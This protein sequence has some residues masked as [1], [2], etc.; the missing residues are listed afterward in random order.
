MARRFMSYT[1]PRLY[2]KD[3]KTLVATPG[4]DMGGGGQ[5]EVLHRNGPW[6]VVRMKGAMA[7]GGNGMPWRY[8]PTRYCAVNVETWEQDGE[9]VEPGRF[10]QKT[11]KELKAQVDA[12][13]GGTP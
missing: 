6:A 1:T 12:L 2:E 3:G 10:W 8:S 4:V 13:A 11:V 7:W 9:A 5:P